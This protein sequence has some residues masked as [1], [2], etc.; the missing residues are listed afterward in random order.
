[1]FAKIVR[2]LSLPIIMLWVLAVLAVNGAVPQL[3]EVV[4]QRAVPLVPDDAPSSIAMM[5]IGRAFQESDSNSV[6]M[7]VLESQNP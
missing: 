5:E 1:M 7:V 4:A 3:E 6:A 2:K